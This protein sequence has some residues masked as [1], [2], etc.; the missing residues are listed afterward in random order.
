MG[1]AAVERRLLDVQRSSEAAVIERPVASAAAVRAANASDSV[2]SEANTR[3]VARNGCSRS[4]AAVSAWRMSYGRESA[5]RA[6][7]A[8]LDVGVGRSAANSSKQGVPDQ[9]DL[10]ARLVGRALRCRIVSPFRIGWGLRHSLLLRLIAHER[11]RRTRH[12]Q[13]RMAS[14]RSFPS[15]PVRI[16]PLNG[17]E[18]FEEVARHGSFSKA[19]DVL[20]ITTSAVSHRIAQLERRLGL[21]LFLRIGHS[22]SL[23]AQGAALLEHV[24]RGLDTLRDGIASL[25][26][27]PDKTIRLSVPPALA[28]N[29]LV[30]R[31]AAFQ[32]AHPD[33]DL[34]I[35]V[36]SRFVDIRAGEA[37]VGLRFGHGAWDGL[38]TTELIR[39]SIFPVCS[40]A[41]RARNPW[42][43]SPADLGRATLLRQAVVPWKPW[44]QAAGLDWPEPTG[45]SSFSEVSLL[46]DAAEHSQGVALVFSALVARRVEVGALVRLFDVELQADGAYYIA[47]AAGVPQRPEVEALVLWLRRHAD[48]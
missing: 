45:G 14:R 35:D 30:Q 26:G 29:W 9:R 27:P 12:S 33:I 40:P 36:T 32:R 7:S 48:A 37:D 23:T 25:G 38:Q 15:P 42:L 19:G 44:F 34:E 21:P 22:V 1:S 31:L 47:V 4:E 2:Q 8:L 18:A 24:R 20:S 6:S 3:A 17:L 11:R 5:R 41:Y 46:I 28:S 43:Q 39:V 16:P 13:E 10:R